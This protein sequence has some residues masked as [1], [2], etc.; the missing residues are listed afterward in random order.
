MNLLLLVLLVLPHLPDPSDD[1][2]PVLV[3]FLALLP[4][5]NALFDFASI[6][7]TRW[8]LRKAASGGGVWGN[9]GWDLLGAAL[10]FLGLGCATVA[11]LH[12]ART[13]DGAP[14]VPLAGET[15][16]FQDMR[17]NPRSYLWLYLTFLS[18]LLPTVLHAGLA[19]F[20][21]P[22]LVLFGANRWIAAR[23]RRGGADGGARWD[24]VAVLSALLTVSLVLPLF[25]L[26]WLWRALAAYHI[27]A[28][29]WLLGIFEGFAG[30][31]GAV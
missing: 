5:L 23:L 12:L 10:L 30:L 20:A 18:T 7:L 22:A 2:Y 9:A 29:L 25:A 24:A 31:I 21:G 27:D 17:D 3:A 11:V 28:G 13:G 15:G 19:L 6:G 4:L 8:R 16:L 14:L 1:D 26:V